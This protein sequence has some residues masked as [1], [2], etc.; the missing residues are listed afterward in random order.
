MAITAADPSGE[1]WASVIPVVFRY[2]SSVMG[3]F[4]VWA[5]EARVMRHR[6]VERVSKK[7]RGRITK[8]INA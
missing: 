7:S 1:R 6:K 8:T 2:S 3:G 5:G 4:A